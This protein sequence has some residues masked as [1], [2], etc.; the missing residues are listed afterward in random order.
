MR[1]AISSST[2]RR[3][4]NNALRDHFNR[5]SRRMNHGPSASAMVSC[6]NVASDDSAP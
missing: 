6:C 1:P 2:C 5:A 4:R 3:P